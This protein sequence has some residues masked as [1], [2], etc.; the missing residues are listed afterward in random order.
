MEIAPILKQ[1]GLSDKEIKVYLALLKAG[2][3]SVRQLAGASGINRGTAYDILKS[4]KEI[5]LVSYYH[6]ATKQFFAAED[7]AQ[8]TNALEQKQERLKEVKNKLNQVIPELKSIYDQAGDKPVVKYYEGNRGIKIILTDVLETVSRQ[9]EKI[10]QVFSS[11][12]IRPFVHCAFPDFTKQRI[13]KNIKVEVIAIGHS[14]TVAP[15]SERKS[16]T[17]HVGSPTYILIYQNKVAMISVNAKREP[18]G[19]I[20]EDEAIFRTQQQLFKFIWQSL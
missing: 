12:A 3:V 4:L 6:Q 11:S 14:G 13:K 17:T 5:G 7:P 18:L 1:F 8:L 2:P 19:L 10:Y 16:L 9:T 15:L 20:I